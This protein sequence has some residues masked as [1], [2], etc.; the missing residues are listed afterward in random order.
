LDGPKAKVAKIIKE[1]QKELKNL[2]N[3]GYT[4]GFL[5]G[6]EAEQDFFGSHQKP[7]FQ[8]VG[9]VIS[10]K[11]NVL[12]IKAHNA[13]R[14]KDKLEAITPSKNISFK[15]KKI[16]NNKM[17]EVQSAHGGH[18]RLFYLKINRSD[19]KLMSLI[20]KKI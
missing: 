17:K 20:Q 7:K 6:K 10:A 9:E 2:M 11:K 19:I 1:Q 12:T 13:L 4:T 14:L 18:E 16:Y 8:F 15:I 3:R 5:L